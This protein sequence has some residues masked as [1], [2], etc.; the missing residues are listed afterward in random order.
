MYYVMPNL[1]TQIIQFGIGKLYT[2]WMCKKFDKLDPNIGKS[3]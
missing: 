3:K 1:A 2:Y